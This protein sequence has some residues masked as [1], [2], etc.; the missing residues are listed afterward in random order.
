MCDNRNK[1]CRQNADRP[2][3]AYCVPI[4][5]GVRVDAYLITIDYAFFDTPLNP[6]AGKTLSIGSL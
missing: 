5:R 3:K 6:E 2:C 4:R 1:R